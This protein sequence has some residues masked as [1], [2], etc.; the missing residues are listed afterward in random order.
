MTKFKNEWQDYE[1][2]IKNYNIQECKKEEYEILKQGFK[3]YILM[4]KKIW[5]I[6]I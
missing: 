1:Q 5:Y 3:K 4:K 6:K 2:W